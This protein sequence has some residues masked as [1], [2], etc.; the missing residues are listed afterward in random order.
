M[1][2]YRSNDTFSIHCAP[3]IS[4]IININIAKQTNPLQMM[5]REGKKHFPK[6]LNANRS[7]KTLER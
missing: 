3:L 4:T 7:A 2:F 6:D 5:I 1:Y